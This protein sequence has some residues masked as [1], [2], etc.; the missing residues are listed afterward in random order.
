MFSKASNPIELTATATGHVVT[1]TVLHDAH[2]AI[3]ASSRVQTPRNTL[4]A[5]QDTPATSKGCAADHPLFLAQKAHPRELAT[6]G[7]TNTVWIRALDPSSPAG[8]ADE[9][10]AAIYV[11]D[12]IG[13]LRPCSIANKYLWQFLLAATIAAAIQATRR[14]RFLQNH[15]ANHSRLRNPVPQALHTPN[16]PRSARL[17]RR[18][19]HPVGTYRAQ[20]TLC[21]HCA[22][23]F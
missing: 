10:P 11:S 12:Q 21:S 5:T 3:R 13:Q 1:A 8:S 20:E 6:I 22:A 2:L 17:A 15:A 18:L 19:A 23:C 14:Q 7:N 9:E 4:K 16:M